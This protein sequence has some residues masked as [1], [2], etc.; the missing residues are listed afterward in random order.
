MF[1][2]TGIDMSAESHPLDGLW[3]LL[4]D[5]QACIGV[6]G[7]GY[8]GMPLARCFARRYPVLGFDR[9]SDHV[10][11]LSQDPGEGDL[12]FTDNEADLRNCR[13]VF[14]RTSCGIL[15]VV[16]FSGISR[17]NTTFSSGAFRMAKAG[18]PRSPRMGGNW[19]RTCERRVCL[20]DKNGSSSKSCW[21]M[22]RHA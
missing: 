3:D 20:S 2:E 4:Q 13:V 12:R 22:A 14:C 6:V 11:R 17:G 21:N 7:L 10:A 19:R 18:N 5:G 9:D 16:R 8:V 1:P 15:A